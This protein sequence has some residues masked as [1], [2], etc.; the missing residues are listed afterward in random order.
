MDAQV[1]GA[2][3]GFAKPVQRENCRALVRIDKRKHQSAQPRAFRPNQRGV[4]TGRAVEV[5]VTSCEL[6]GSAVSRK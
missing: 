5:R 2:K 4:A 3:A 6:K 1:K